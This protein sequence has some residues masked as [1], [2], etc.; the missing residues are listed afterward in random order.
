M[1]D[2]ILSEAE[3][4]EDYLKRNMQYLDNKPIFKTKM[5]QE[6]LDKR[7]NAAQHRKLNGA[8]K[9]AGAAVTAVSVD[10]DSKEYIS[11]EETIAQLQG[12]KDRVG[13]LRN[14]YQNH[15]ASGDC[16][17]ALG[18]EAY[19]YDVL[20]GLAK[21]KSFHLASN[22]SVSLLGR[23]SLRLG[24]GRRGDLRQRRRGPG[25]QGE[26]HSGRGGHHRHEG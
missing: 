13:I 24:R 6:I 14:Y 12:E 15:Q 2:H 11:Q 9:V 21:D 26:G 18:E 16:L 4:Q 22:V 7:Y 19:C 17:K 1:I 23:E 20:L 3:R 5:Q 25:P 10:R 8:F